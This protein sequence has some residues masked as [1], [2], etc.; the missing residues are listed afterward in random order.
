MK[1]A[2][3]LLCALLLCLLA[4]CGGD[5]GEA[6]D[7]SS[8]SLP[9]L[10]VSSSPEVQPSPASGEG[11]LESAKLIH[12][13]EEE[14]AAVM[15]NG[16]LATFALPEKISFAPGLGDQLKPGMTVEVAY[17][18]KMARSYPG[19]IN[20]ESL[21]ATAY[22]DGL[23]A[24]YFSVLEDLYGEPD[25]GLNGEC[26]YFGFDLTKAEG[27]SAGE[28]EAVGWAFAT[29]HDC[30]PLYGTIEELGAQGYI[31]MESLA[32]KDGL[33]FEIKAEDV[34]EDRFT[35][36]CTKWRSGLG[37]SGYKL[38]VEKK[39]GVWTAAEP[40]EFWVA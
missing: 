28:R 26:L 2:A 25:A 16:T 40:S 9:S 10:V 24:L 38:A 20:A 19:Q 12:L 31:D 35:L 7:P 21:R 5:S 34:S 11:V 27:L 13:E 4:A 33:H 18:G 1:K 32:W 37:A 8:Q 14:A 22:D 39:D 23:T 3:A 36:N 6:L 15:E 29:A 30:A 17:D